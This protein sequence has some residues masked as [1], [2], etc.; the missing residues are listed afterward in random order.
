[1]Y[2][3]KYNPITLEYVG[4]VN[5]PL[6]PE[7]TKTTGK[8]C[9]SLPLNTTF[10]KPPQ[11]NKFKTAL[12]N[13]ENDNWDVVPDYRGELIV[14]SSM[15]IKIVQQIG[16]LPE[17]YIPIS[18]QEA[19]IITNDPLYYIIDNGEL[20]ENPNYEEDKAKQEAER[21]ARLS[22]TKYDFYKVVCKPNGIDYQQV[23]A[24]I[25]SNDDIAAA[26]NFCERVYRGDE[27]LNT[28]IKQFIPSITD[29]ILDEIFKTYGA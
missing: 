26:W 8:E 10:T 13:E 23:M 14:N 19:E 1:M 21:V 29:A 4:S 12:Y 5:A 22:M 15:N 20:I 18:E 3:Y 2:C 16:A 27:L 24:L 9:Y 28:Y 7:T 17:G 6:D 11:T 25:N